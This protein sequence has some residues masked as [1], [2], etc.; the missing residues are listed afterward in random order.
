MDMET[1]RLIL[2][3]SPDAMP[4]PEPAPR[5]RS[6]LSSA[7]RS[8]VHI[9]PETG[10]LV[11]EINPGRARLDERGLP[12]IGP[13]P[14]PRRRPERGP[15]L[16]S[17]RHPLSDFIADKTPL[18]SGVGS[19]MDT[20]IDLGRAAGDAAKGMS[21]A[22]LITDW[23]V[24]SGERL[25]T[26][27]YNWQP[28]LP[29]KALRL[30]T[31][32]SAEAQTAEQKAKPKFDQGSYDRQKEM[33]DAGY[34]IKKLD[35]IWGPETEKIWQQFL[36]DKPKRDREKA[37]KAATER[38]AAAAAQRAA[39]DQANAGAAAETARAQAELARAQLAETE[40]KRKAEEA[41]ALAKAERDRQNILGQQKYDAA[42]RAKNPWIKAAEDNAT[43]LGFVGGM[44][45]GKGI[46]HGV[47]ENFTR[48]SAKEANAANALL[49][50][51]ATSVPGR[52]WIGRALPPYRLP[53]DRSRS[54][55]RRM[56]TTASP[57]STA[58]GRRV[59]GPEARSPKLCSASS[60]RRRRSSRCRG[61]C[62]ASSL[63]RPRRRFRGRTRSI[64]RQAPTARSTSGPTPP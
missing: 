37:A 58:S 6:P 14:P 63:T 16:R 23:A 62:P 8:G 17:A 42:Q 47:V 41:A 2:A 51:G 24:P 21:G 22:S 26:E 25:A 48:R 4:D 28:D 9:D 38:E 57:T 39:T 19:A 29:E 59:S 64:A 12:D 15:E 32:M 60:R 55:P 1:M 30:I 61:R 10:R 50:G 56:W 53:G 7:L 5:G 20:V 44:L 36:A 27:L 3:Q 34:P 11:V 43:A 35:G 18:P 45:I 52:N 40:R 46:K 13:P 54:R 31:P 33:I 49:P